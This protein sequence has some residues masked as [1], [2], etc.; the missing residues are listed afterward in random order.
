MRPT[1]DDVSVTASNDLAPLP[2]AVPPTCAAPGSGASD[3]FKRTAPA[4]SLGC[5]DSGQTW[6]NA[7]DSAWTIC[8]DQRACAL[9]P[10]GGSSWA[11]IETGLTAQRVSATIAPRPAGAVGQAGIL[12]GLTPDWSTSMLYVGLDPAGVAEVW[13][14]TDGAW[15]SMAL[16]SA[17]T[18]KDATSARTLEARASGGTLEVLVDGARVI[19]PIQVPARPAN[20]TMAGLYADTSGP[21]AAWPRFTAFAVAPGP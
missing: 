20:G 17:S 12:V 6:E 8:D 3:A 11:R 9:A 14:V 16:A 7:V 10:P 2:T 4:G 1:L 5:A 19:G 21:G 13:S 15:S 18:A